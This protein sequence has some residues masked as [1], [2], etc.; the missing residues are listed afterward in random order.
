MPRVGKLTSRE[1]RLDTR[2]NQTNYSA[3]SLACEKVDETCVSV[4]IATSWYPKNKGGSAE[5][6]NSRQGWNH[7][8]P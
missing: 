8:K 1:E 7:K 6:E 3:Q 2:A 4:I 5:E